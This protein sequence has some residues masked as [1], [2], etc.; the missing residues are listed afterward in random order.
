MKTTPKLFLACLFCFGLSSTIGYTN[1]TDENLVR[2]EQW[3]RRAANA[4]HP[5]AQRL[6]MW[7]RNATEQGDTEATEVPFIV[8]RGHIGS[9][10]SARFSPDGTKMITVSGHLH[11][12]TGFSPDNTVRIWEAES[13]TELHRL[14]GHG[15]RDASADFFPDG[16]KIATS[17]GGITRIWETESG[18]ELQRLTGRTHWNISSAISSDGTKIVTTTNSGTA[19]IWEVESGRKLQTIGE[20]GVSLG[21]AHFSPDGKKIITS[22][23][24]QSTRIS[25]T[26]LE[27][28]LFISG[29][30]LVVVSPD[31]KNIVVASDGGNNVRIL[32]SE[33][34]SELQKLKI[35]A[36]LRWHGIWQ[37]PIVFSPDGQHIVTSGGGPRI[38]SAKSGREVQILKGHTSRVNSIAF[39]PDGRKFITANGNDL[40]SFGRQSD[41]TARIWDTESGRELHVLRGHTSEVNSAHFSPDGMKVVTASSDGTA[42]IWDLSAAMQP[43]A[44]ADHRRKAQHEQ[45]Y[46][47]PDKE[48][49]RNDISTLVEFARYGNDMVKDRVNALN[50][51][52]DL[53]EPEDEYKVEVALKTVRARI[54]QK[55]FYDEYVY[56]ISDKQVDGDSSSFTMTIPTGFTGTKV[57]EVLFPIP[58]VA[59]KQIDRIGIMLSVSGTADGVREL[60]D[61]CDHYRVAVWFTNL[62]LDGRNGA[63]ADVMKIE[64]IKVR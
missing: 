21:P 57:D 64:V 48:R 44:N 4:E 46:L 3:L 29:E 16:K 20:D 61:N 17:S 63:T 25:D 34:G 12:V 54:A 7:V 47:D 35:P 30:W 5:D 55:R 59:G 38:W 42:R 32:S 24:F 50:Q 52:G 2:A 51:M 19:Q 45:G 26:G 14:T 27:R 28:E 1:D 37:S 41:N 31:G 23:P 15:E 62:R 60:V 18:K 22:F 58:D 56:S 33:S 9:V 8:L 43:W 11:I 49:A 39:S 53:A 36:D 40:V 10:L 13:G 6:R